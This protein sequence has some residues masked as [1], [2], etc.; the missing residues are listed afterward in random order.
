ML[1]EYINNIYIGYRYIDKTIYLK[2]D[3]N[4]VINCTNDISF[5]DI[6]NIKK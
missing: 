3:I 6:D 2:H 4:I 1:I 5:I